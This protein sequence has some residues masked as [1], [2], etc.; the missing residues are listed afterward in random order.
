MLLR[1]DET[2]TK[3]QL[4]KHL[5]VLK[6]SMASSKEATSEDESVPRSK[7]MGTVDSEWWNISK[8]DG[9]DG[10]DDIDKERDLLTYFGE[11]LS[12]T[13]M[14]SGSWIAFTACFV[15]CRLITKSPMRHL[16]TANLRNYSFIE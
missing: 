6:Q 7:Q 15:F 3:I 2:K 8:K 11:V 1:H 14:P 13:K 5:T 16:K 4:K 9:D 12:C 10:S